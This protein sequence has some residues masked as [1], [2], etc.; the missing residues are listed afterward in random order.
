MDQI[1]NEEKRD[2]LIAHFTEVAGHDVL[3]NQDALMIIEII[4]DA[5][6]RKQAT[7]Y[8]DIITRMIEYGVEEEE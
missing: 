6:E 5:C 8:E 4:K 3:T 7:M 1:L 2:A